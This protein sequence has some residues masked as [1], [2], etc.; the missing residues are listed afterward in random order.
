MD[1]GVEGGWDGGGWLD[2]GRKNGGGCDED[3]SHWC[4]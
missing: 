1:E 2:G 3:G 4:D